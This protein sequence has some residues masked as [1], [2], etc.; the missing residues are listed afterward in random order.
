MRTTKRRSAG[1]IRGFW[2]HGSA[3]LALMLGWTLGLISSQA[4]ASPFDWERAQLRTTTYPEF[5]QGRLTL[6]EGIVEEG[7][8]S[9]V[10][11]TAAWSDAKGKAEAEVELVERL[12]ESPEWWDV[13]LQGDELL[14]EHGA[15]GDLDAG[16]TLT[17]H[18]WKW[19]SNDH[20][21]GSHT[22]SEY[23]PFDAEREAIRQLLDADD[24]PAARLVLGIVEG[25]GGGHVDSD[26]TFLA[27]FDATYRLAR[28]AYD[29]GDSKGASEAFETL[30]YL[31]PPVLSAR[32]TPSEGSLV[33]RLPS[34]DGCGRFNQLPNT[35]TVIQRLND[36]AFFL[37]LGGHHQEAIE[38][39]EQ[40]VAVEPRRTAAHLNLA[41]ALWGV[42]EAQEA[43][44][45]YEL[46][47]QLL[48][49]DD[50]HKKV[51]AYVL[52]RLGAER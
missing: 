15:C 36:A 41:D 37:D 46:F 4:A 52:E 43:K 49:K 1:G 17:V 24:L 34:D 47:R 26:E 12:C 13:D 32:C 30:F 9:R 35:P 44:V 20:V 2:T 19:D 22:I 3:A 39:L 16:G 8:S 33:I 10:R 11:L 14:A 18:R 5:D 27:F 31:D 25:A 40:L 7:E 28:K 51:P 42:G 23:S 48:K 6:R 21:F 38:L 45:H 29:A 50:R